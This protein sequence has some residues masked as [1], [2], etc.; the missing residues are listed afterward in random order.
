MKKKYSPIKCA[1][2]FSMSVQGN[3]GAYCTPKDD[4]GPYFSVEVGYP[5]A[6]EPL[7]L[8]YAEN[9]STP[10]STIYGWVPSAVVL[11]VIERHGGWESGE[12]PPMEIC[13][14]DESW[15]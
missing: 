1:D 10:T 12:M 3:E 2:G 4:Q 11:E 14:N 8:P 7:L 5:S 15:I 13:D 6:S 9:P